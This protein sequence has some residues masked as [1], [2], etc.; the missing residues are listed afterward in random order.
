[1]PPKIFIET[2]AGILIN[3]ILPLKLLDEPIDKICVLADGVYRSV[4]KYELL[5]YGFFLKEYIA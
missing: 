1:M 3:K 4:L 2:H 5:Q